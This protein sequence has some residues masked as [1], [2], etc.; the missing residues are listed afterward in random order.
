MITRKDYNN[1]FI[2]NV[3]MVDSKLSFNTINVQLFYTRI[4]VE[5]K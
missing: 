4:N 1:I 5:K 3:T 2:T